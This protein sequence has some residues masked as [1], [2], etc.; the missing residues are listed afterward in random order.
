MAIIYL[1]KPPKRAF[2]KDRPVSDLVRR[3]VE[4]LEW[5]VRPAAERKPGKL[6]IKRPRTEGE[7]AARIEYLT[8]QLHPEGATPAAV[9]P[10]GATPAKESQP[11]PTRKRKK[12]RTKKQRAKGLATRKAKRASKSRGRSK[13]SRRAR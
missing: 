3:Q 7:A 10:A 12:Q 4:H 6:K 13:S 11:A 9:T 8:K 1:P 2:N 5:A